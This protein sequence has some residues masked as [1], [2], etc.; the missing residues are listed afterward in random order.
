VWDYRSSSPSCYTDRA[1]NRVSREGGG[2]P[3]AQM[4]MGATAGAELV[5]MR[6]KALAD[7]AARRLALQVAMAASSKSSTPALAPPGSGDP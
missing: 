1:A 3:Q 2:R 6:G 7:S 4:A 5:G